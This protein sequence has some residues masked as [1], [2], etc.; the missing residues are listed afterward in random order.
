VKS[1]CL[2]SMRIT[3]GP[4]E[5]FEALIHVPAAVDLS[6]LKRD[7]VVLRQGCPVQLL[8]LLSPKL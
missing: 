7:S 3:F 5:S 6:A 4:P 8:R 1:G 2:E